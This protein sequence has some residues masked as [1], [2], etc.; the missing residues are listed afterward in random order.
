MSKN[1]LSKNF[2]YKDKPR[3]ELEGLLANMHGENYPVEAKNGLIKEASKLAPG[4]GS[5]LPAVTNADNGKVLSVVDGAWAADEKRF[6][7][8]LTPTAAD[9]SGTMDKT[10]GQILEAYNSGKEI[11]FAIGEAV[12]IPIAAVDT[13]DVGSKIFYA[14]AI[15][16]RQNILVVMKTTPAISTEDTYNTYD[17]TIYKL[18][19]MG[20]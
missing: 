14:N 9:Y 5:S 18:T 11:W 17:T 3:N 13:S 8:T 6:V 16:T 1:P 10:T 2:V 19:P 15:L 20:T 4:S 7:V 12:C